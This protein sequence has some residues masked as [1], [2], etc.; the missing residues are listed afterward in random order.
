MKL[1]KHDGNLWHYRMNPEEAESLRAVVGCF[2]VAGSS[3]IR[4][5]KSDAD[6]ATIER[7]KWLNESLAEHRKELQRKTKTLI[8]ADRFKVQK[9]NVVFQINSEDREML[10]QILNDIRIDSWRILGEPE[11]LEVDL[12]KIPSDQLRHY[13]LL[14]LSGY[15]E[16]HLLVHTDG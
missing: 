4:I 8:A 7:G 11:E 5:S 14:H 2:P 3:A 12:Q 16:H 6:P 10:L 15:F 1:A 13:Q 9:V